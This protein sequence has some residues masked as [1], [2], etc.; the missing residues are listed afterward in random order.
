LTR[1]RGDL[2]GNSPSKEGARN[3]V[4]SLGFS[5]NGPFLA[6]LGSVGRARH[7]FLSCGVLGCSRS[8]VLTSEEAMISKSSIS[9]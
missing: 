8:S 5:D 9:G 2:G 6:P 4:G 3:L 7:A 1:S